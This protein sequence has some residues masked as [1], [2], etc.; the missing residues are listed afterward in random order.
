LFRV[1]I[2]SQLYRLFALDHPQHWSVERSGE[3]QGICTWKQI[4]GFTSPIWLAIPAELD[5]EAVLALLTKVRRSLQVSQPLSLNYPA[6]LA[7]E[8]LR[9]AGFYPH[10][11]LIW[12]EQKLSS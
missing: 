5:G 9:Q 7:T 6:G 11:T 1:D 8:A 4:S 2:W 10:Q 3:L 12:M